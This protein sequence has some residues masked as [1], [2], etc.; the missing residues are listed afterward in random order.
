MKSRLDEFAPVY[1][2][3]E[4]HAIRVRAS[5]ERVFEA[6]RQVT[7]QEIRLFRA[8]TWIRRLGRPGPEDILR[9]PEEQPLIDVAIRTTFVLLAEVPA[10]EL[11]VGTLVMAPPGFRAKD[12][13][14]P[15]AF[16]DLA[17]PGF[18]KAT[19]NFLFRCRLSYLPYGFEPRIE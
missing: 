17:R 14:D 4:V 3:H 6:V 15:D 7:A 2:F 8:L 19:M 9:A 1:Q 5:P 12:R 16:R 13:R 18:A 11:V 10:Q